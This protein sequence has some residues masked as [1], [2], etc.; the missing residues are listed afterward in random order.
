MCSILGGTVL[1]EFAL[2]VYKNAKSRGKDFAGLC[3]NR[4]GLWIANHRATPTTEVNN[5][6]QNQPFGVAFKVVH[7]GTIQNDKELG[8]VAGDMDSFVLTT[9]LDVKDLCTLADSLS[10]VNGSYAIAILKDNEILLACNYKPIWLLYKD[11]ELYFSSLQEHLGPDA[12]RMTPYSVMN[13]NTGQTL[14]IPRKQSDSAV[15]ICSGGLDSTV[16]ATMARNKHKNVTLLHFQ[17]GCRAET[18]ETDA[19]KQIAHRLTCD[20][21]VVELPYVKM[22]GNSPLLDK[23]SAIAEGV[24]GSEYAF[25]WVPA[26]NFL[27]MAYATAYAEANGFGHIY[28]GTNLEEGGAYPDNE[29]QFIRDVN[30]VLW[31]AVQNGVKIE[32]HS[33]LGS[34]MKR[35]IVTAGSLIGAPFELSYSCYHGAEYHCGNCGPCFMRKTAFKRALVDDPTIYKV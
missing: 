31:G 6:N 16:V 13:L 25:E 32:I 3:Q 15:V 34:M 35:D 7:N 28:L 24:A 11:G 21:D 30:S 29:E 5:P 19:I 4:N 20:F 8:A 12:I 33:P 10:R 2:Q 1:D 9:C 17:Y 26:R 18:V 22:K 23:D 14:A 27:F